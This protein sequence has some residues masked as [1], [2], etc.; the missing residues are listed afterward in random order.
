MA[1]DIR[2]L[3]KKALDSGIPPEKVKALMKEGGHSDAEIEAA[4]SEPVKNEVPIKSPTK[5]TPLVKKRSNIKIILA[6]VLIAIIAVSAI[7][8]WTTNF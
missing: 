4:F 7:F 8:L 5:K 1:E 2:T 6:I 3:V